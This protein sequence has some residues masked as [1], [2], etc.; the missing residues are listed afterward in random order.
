MQKLLTWAK[1]HKIA[2]GAIGCG[3][4][5]V[6]GLVLLIIAGLILTAVGYEPEETEE[7]EAVATT[8]AAATPEAEEVATTPACHRRGDA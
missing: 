3:G 5:I 4:L 8:Q 2:A 1:S 7:P 6:G